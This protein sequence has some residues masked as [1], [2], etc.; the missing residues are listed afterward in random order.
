MQSGQDAVDVKWMT[1]R[2]FEHAQRGGT[3]VTGAHELADI[4]KMLIWFG[5]YGGSEL[6]KSVSQTL[7]HSNDIINSTAHV[8]SV[9]STTIHVAASDFELDGPGS[10][11]DNT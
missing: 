7:L 6:R 4:L 10:S 9:S 1:Y 5:E 8:Y 2:L 11:D 3:V